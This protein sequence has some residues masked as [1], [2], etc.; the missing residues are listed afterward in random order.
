MRVV[1]VLTKGN[2]DWNLYLRTRAQSS[3]Q[4]VSEFHSYL[5]LPPPP[6]LP[7]PFYLNWFVHFVVCKH[8]YFTTV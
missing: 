3:F 7:L 2:I 5:S 6:P 8:S 1:T 4:T